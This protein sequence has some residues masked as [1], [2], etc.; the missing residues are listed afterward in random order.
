MKLSPIGAGL[1]LVACAT[2]P[3][4]A[5]TVKRTKCGTAEPVHVIA[6]S[7][8]FFDVDV[9]DQNGERLFTL[10]GLKTDQQKTF[11]AKPG[12]GTHFILDPI[13]GGPGFVVDGLS[14]PVAGGTVLIALGSLLRISF[15]DVVGPAPE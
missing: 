9:R 6:R 7:A 1:L 2:V 8:F 15:V 4:E 3:R 14:E 13:G 10:E 12:R 5:P 11:C